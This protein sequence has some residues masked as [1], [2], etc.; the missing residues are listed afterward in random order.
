MAAESEVNERVGDFDRIDRL[1]KE[2]L[3]GEDDRES[4]CALAPLRTKS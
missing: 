1:A 4:R 3:G 2:I